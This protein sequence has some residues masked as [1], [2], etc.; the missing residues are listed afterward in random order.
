LNFFFLLGIRQIE[1]IVS[2]K[3]IEDRV[4]NPAFFLAIID[5]IFLLSNFIEE[6]F[7]EQVLEGV[8]KKL[9]V[10]FKSFCKRVADRFLN[11]LYL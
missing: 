5:K 1:K 2:E 4:G 7:R 8:T 9:L 3:R 6:S 10:T 11:F